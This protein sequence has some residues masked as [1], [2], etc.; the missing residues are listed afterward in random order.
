MYIQMLMFL[1]NL[2]IGYHH[3]RIKNHILLLMKVLRDCKYIKGNILNSKCI[4]GSGASRLGG[5]RVVC[6]NELEILFCSK[7]CSYGGTCW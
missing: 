6:D 7:E 4:E 2:F 5:K 3:F 1:T